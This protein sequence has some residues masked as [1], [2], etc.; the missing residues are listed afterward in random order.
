MSRSKKSGPVRAVFV[1]LVLLAAASGILPSVLPSVLKAQA[2]A[3]A[4]ARS[5]PIPVVVIRNVHL[6]DGVRGAFANGATLV[7]RDGLIAS[8]LTGNE[9]RSYSPPAD[10]TVI[11]GRGR[12]VLPG[13]IDAHT[14][15]ASTA[16]ARR[17]L[18]S[19]VTTV[20]SASVSAFQDVALREAVRE[21]VLAGPDV[22][23]AGMFITPQMGDAM[24]G[25][26]R[27]PA[28]KGRMETEAGL[29][30]A[31]RINV[32]RGAN[33]IKT[34]GTERAGLP[35]TD[36]RKQ[37]YTEQQLGWIVDEAT[38]HN[39]PVLAHAHG[40]EGALAAVRAGVRS[41]EHGTFMSDS[42][43]GLMKEMG[44]F[45]VPTYITVYDLTQPGGDYDDPV[46]T[47]RGNFMLPV[48]GETIKRAHA[49]GIPIATGC[50]TEYGPPSL[51]RVSGE[52][53]FFVELGFTPIEAIRSATTVG[54]ALLGIDGRVGQIREGYEA[55]LILVESDPLKDIRSLADVLVVVSNGRVALN[56]TPFAKTN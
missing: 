1:S 20:R 38:K 37:A 49:M 12:Y 10:A 54:A 23:A 47:N 14:H 6:I 25:D 43:L 34:R 2:A 21:G 19:G 46:L 36:P 15:L 24:L 5:L 44:T 7:L 32:D 29:R 31:V 13:L 28:L 40:D 9:A 27:L 8:V 55:D 39:V 35:E 26:P 30:E 50:D 16:S 22:L 4:R 51:S 45:F 11:D 18:E 48:L 17:A 52:V 3:S 42:T 41:I 56:R 53:A 33:V